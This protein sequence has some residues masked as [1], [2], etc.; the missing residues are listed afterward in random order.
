M[1]GRDGIFTL[2]YAFSFWQLL[3]VVKELE[4]TQYLHCNILYFTVV[5]TM[6]IS[7]D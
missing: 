2:T 6:Q 5:W 3:L 7:P 4:D 1:E